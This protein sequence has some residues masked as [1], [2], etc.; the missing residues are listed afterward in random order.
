MTNDIAKYLYEM[1]QMKRVQ[2]SGW[3]LAGIVNPETVAEHSFRT[4]ILGYILASLE[5]ADATKTTMMCLFH[6]THET[7]INDSHRV[8][9]R[10]INTDVG[11][12]EAFQE[13]VE[14]LPQKMAASITSLIVDYEGK[15]S[16]EAQVAHDADLL[17]CLIQAREYQSQG[18]ADVEDWIINCQAG[19]KTASA[20]NLAQACIE[21]E[22]KSW[23]Q[24]LMKMDET[25][26]NNQ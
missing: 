4:A 19:L 20:K 9:K 24:G 7:R 8:V 23:W 1:G 2:R 22:P 3:W 15:E 10:Y 17:E 11:E 25:L 26:K 21:T 18:Y 5:G 16:M 12:M 6:D 14:R 13:Q